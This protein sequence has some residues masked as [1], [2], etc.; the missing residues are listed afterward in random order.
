MKL[1]ITTEDKI[2]MIDLNDLQRKRISFQLLN[3][4]DVSLDL[5]ENKIKEY[6]K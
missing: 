2:Y 1:T 4:L 3:D 6:E 5:E